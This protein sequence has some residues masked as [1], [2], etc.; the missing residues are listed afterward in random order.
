M[1]EIRKF[2]V[3]SHVTQELQ[4][5]VVWFKT[6]SMQNGDNSNSNYN[7]TNNND[8]NNGNTDNKHKLITL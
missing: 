2:D 3:R 6:S 7:N 8:N 1:C 5:I 4:E